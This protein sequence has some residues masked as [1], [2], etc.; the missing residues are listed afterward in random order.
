MAI[1]HEHLAV[2]LFI[3]AIVA[4]AFGMLLALF[5][6]FRD[7]QLGTNKPAKRFLVSNWK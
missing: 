1:T 5:L 2:I 4:V 3:F 6:L 7:Q